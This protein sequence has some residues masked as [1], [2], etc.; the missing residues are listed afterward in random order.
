VPPPPPPSNPETRQLLRDAGVKA[1][2]A[3]RRLSGL[4]PAIVRQ[5]LAGLRGES[6]LKST[7]A[8]LVAALDA[9]LGDPAL[10]PA[11]A[12]ASTNGRPPPSDTEILRSPHLDAQQRAL[13]LARY[14]A[15]APTPEARW[16]VLE[17]LRAEVAAPT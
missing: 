14:R 10:L 1:P 2:A 12:P 7:A 4:D 9:C 17:R 3:L 5:V 16:A 13:W 6:G 8:V 11:V 15:A